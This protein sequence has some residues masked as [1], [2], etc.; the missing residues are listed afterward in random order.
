VARLLCI[1]VTVA[2]LARAQA[3]EFESGGLRYQAVT[4]KGVTVMVA[5][6]PTRVLG[7]AILQ[8]A[9][10][11]GSAE[12]TQAV[13]E[14]FRYVPTLGKAAQALSARAVVNDV[15]RR[16]GRGDVGRLIG[17]YE[18]ALFGSSN[19][20]LRHGYEA[21]RKDAMAVGGSKIRAAAAAAAIVMGAS[22]LDPGASTD[23]AVFF[24]TS[25]K[26][27]GAGTLRFEMA[28]ER[29]EFTLAAPVATK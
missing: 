7:Y 20:E 8:V 9:I 23:G 26:P 5:P 19:L 3:I 6:L 1:L 10:A 29:F 25:N 18:T 16:A 4:K 13:P 17:V 14:S 21:R 27:L 28:G 22:K 12:A 15:L 11:N 2:W 24:P